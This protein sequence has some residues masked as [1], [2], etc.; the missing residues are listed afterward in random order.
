MV[1]VTVMAAGVTIVLMKLEQCCLRMLSSPRAA[2]PVTAA[3]QASSPRL[4]GLAKA[5]P[6]KAKAGTAK[7]VKKDGIIRVK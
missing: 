3:K 2:L 7:E 4:S 6:A 5:L 1:V